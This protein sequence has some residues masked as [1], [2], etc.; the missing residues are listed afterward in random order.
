MENCFLCVV[1]HFTD[2]LQCPRRA[3]KQ[4]VRQSIMTRVIQNSFTLPGMKINNDLSCFR[5]SGHLAR[6]LLVTKNN[7]STLK[8]TESMTV[9]LHLYYSNTFTK[10][11]QTGI[12]HNAKNKTSKFIPLLSACWGRNNT[13]CI[14]IKQP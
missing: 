10:R 6:K 14:F 7:D 9:I 1:K 2:V 12:S 11:S 13:V 8:E 4:S 3:L 5:N